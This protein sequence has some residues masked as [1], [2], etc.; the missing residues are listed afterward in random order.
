MVNTELVDLCIAHQLLLLSL[1]GLL[2]LSIVANHEEIPSDIRNFAFQGRKW[3]FWRIAIFYRNIINY[4]CK[5]RK[6]N[7]RFNL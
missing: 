7:V 5:L 3:K 4:V 6:W 2:V 1:L